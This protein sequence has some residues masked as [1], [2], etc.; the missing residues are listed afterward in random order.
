MK[1]LALLRGINA[2]GKR[3]VP[4]EELRKVFEGLAFGD[5]ETY[6]NSGN[7][8]FNSKHAP[9]QSTIQ[10]AIREQFGFDVDT[11]IINEEELATIVAAIPSDWQNDYTEHKSDVAFLFDDINSPDMIEVLL[12]RPE[13]ETILYIDHALL[14]NVARK[15]QSKSSLARSIGSSHYRRMTIRNI[16]TVKKLAELMQ[17]H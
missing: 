16:T 15:N 6:I 13:I 3:R 7:V 14:S 9:K 10:E 8:I 11:L 12:P 17:Q 4:M 1:Y 2:G 5:V